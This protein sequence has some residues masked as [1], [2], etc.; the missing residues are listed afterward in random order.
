MIPISTFGGF[1]GDLRVYDLNGMLTQSALHSLPMFSGTW[2]ARKI[3]FP[4]PLGL[5][6]VALLAA[7][8]SPNLGNFM[9]FRQI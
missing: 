5:C 4:E 9:Q 8:Y 1:L 6:T 2:S 3:F 7:I